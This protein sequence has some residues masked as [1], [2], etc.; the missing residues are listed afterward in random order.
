RDRWAASGWENGVLGYPTTDVTALAGGGRFAHF[1]HGSIYWT[2]ATGA[3]IV[4]GAVRDRWAGGGWETGALGFPTTDVLP[5]PGGGAFAHFQGGSIYWT[6]ATGARIVSGAVRDRW[7][8]SGWENGVLGYP[9]TDVT[10][11]AG[12][13]RFAHF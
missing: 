9:T 10:A 5:L 7:A 11:L 1:E 8:A 3:R 4:T 2:Q 13:G 12:G 6:Q